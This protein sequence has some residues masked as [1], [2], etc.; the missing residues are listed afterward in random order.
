MELRQSGSRERTYGLPIMMSSALARVTATERQKEVRRPFSVRENYDRMR[1][2]L[3][4]ESTRVCY[5]A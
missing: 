3:T 1:D 2:L 4:V 5:K